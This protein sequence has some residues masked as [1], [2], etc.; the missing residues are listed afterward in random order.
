MLSDCRLQRSLGFWMSL[1][2]VSF[3]I[4]LF[5]V[6]VLRSCSHTVHSALLSDTFLAWVKGS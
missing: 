3:G 2:S 5:S 1:P 6:L 4:M